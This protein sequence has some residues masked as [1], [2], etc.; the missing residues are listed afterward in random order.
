[1]IKLFV[2]TFLITLLILCIAYIVV[3]I[4]DMKAEKK[5]KELVIQAVKVR[6]IEICKEK[7]YK[8][9]EY[10]VIEAIEVL[11][12]EVYRAAM[13]QAAKEYKEDPRNFLMKYGMT[14]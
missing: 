6:I 13:E 2:A 3:A 7:G 8:Q 11:G 9:K 1:M 12:I 14:K 10:S 4:M 5:R